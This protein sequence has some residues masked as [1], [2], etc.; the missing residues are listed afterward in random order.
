MIE[1]AS[2]T[3]TDAELQEALKEL[4]AEPPAE[5]KPVV[6][7]P[8]VEEKKAS[9][10]KVEPGDKAAVETPGKSATGTEPVKAE[11]Q[12]V[13]GVESA[14]EKEKAKGGWQRK[15]EKLT[16]L[17]DSFK[18]QLEEEKG[19][20]A[21]L[22]AK[23]EDAEAQLAEV[24]AAKPSEEAPKVTG[25][26]R[27]KRPTLADSEFDQEKYDAALT[28]YDAEMDAYYDKMADIKAESAVA[29]D[30]ERRATEAKQAQEAKFRQELNQRIEVGKA[31][32]DDYQEMLDAAKNTPTVCD[33]EVGGEMSGVALGYIENA[34][35]PGDLIYYLAKD[36]AENGAKESKRLSGLSA[37]RLVIELKAIED[38]ILS[39]REKA[40][41]PKVVPEP[42]KK[43]EPPVVAVET[44]KVEPPAKPE[45]QVAKVPDDPIEPLGGRSSAD[46]G[47]L[48][49]QIEAAAERGDGPEVRR[50][51][52]QQRIAAGRAAGRI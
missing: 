35:N 43:E 16:K 51:R 18:D 47:N 32:Y 42:P 45:K 50:L 14:E 7:T 38:K 46:P 49:K 31:K 6:A 34:D 17:V 3:A 12:V 24:H 23:L 52:D 5:E 22:R 41:A 44:P 20:K 39:E 25:P 21:R 15:V 11:T 19:D 37:F 1:L 40:A 10:P 28:K 13:P 29:K 8:P 27:P 48:T 2:N 33:K 36:A 9:E 26:V 4:G 30:N